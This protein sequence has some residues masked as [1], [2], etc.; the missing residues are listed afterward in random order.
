MP[1]DSSSGALHLP[2]LSV[3]D[4]VSLKRPL[5]ASMRHT[6]ATFDGPGCIDHLWCTLHHPQKTVMINRKLVLRIYFED[7]EVPHVEAPLG[8]FFGVMHGVGAYDVN[9]PHLSVKQ[10]SGYNCY[11]PMPFARSARIEIETGDEDNHLYLQADW[12]RFPHE[13]L[14]EPR[15]F[16]A[17]WRKENPTRRY[18]NDYL[19][20]DAD[21]PGHL[22]GFVY[23]VRLIDNE[24]RWSHGG[25]ENVYIDGQGEHPAFIRGIGG[26]DTFGASYGGAHHPP[27]THLWSGVPYYEHEDIGEARRVQRLVGYRFFDRDPIPFRESI[28]VRFGCMQNN[29]CST[30]YWYQEGAPRPFVRLPGFA[31]LMP[32]APVAAADVDL[33]LPQS[34]GW[35]ARLPLDNEDGQAITA[36]L[37]HGVVA[38]AG[39]DWHA[40]DAH[41][42]FID[43]NH[44]DRP[45]VRG[46]GTFHDGKAAAARTILVA[47][48]AMRATLRFSYDDHLVYQLN[49]DPAVDLGNHA[50]FRTREAQVALRAGNNDL[51]LMLGNTRNSNHGGWA[52]AFTAVC[53]DG[54]HLRPSISS[55]GED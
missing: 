21:G 36:A 50:A 41:H 55:G 22:V 17:R 32:D 38:A 30:V 20:L 28:H 46:V 51:A 15:R 19:M 4:R 45:R 14:A 52:L 48:T 29:I 5:A 37:A 1:P 39:D 26:E 42:G 27:E 18:G 25:A 6:V 3:R 40:C 12:R 44:L 11:F 33:P 10:Y 54:M 8:D 16:C 53:E 49:A 7:S 13:P 24:D 34:G 35:C 31:G 9:T 23:G 43:F 2:R 47:P